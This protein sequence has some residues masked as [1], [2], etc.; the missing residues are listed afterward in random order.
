MTL[1]KD[2]VHSN[3]LK[4]HQAKM[5][6]ETMSF[7]DTFG[8]NSK[9]KRVTLDVNTIEDFAKRAEKLD[10]D[11]NDK[12]EEALALKMQSGSGDLDE[13]E[14]NATAREAIFSKGQSKRIWNEL[15]K[16]IDSSDVIIHGM[17]FSLMLSFVGHFAHNGLVL[18][19]RDPLGTRCRGIEKYI[20]EEAAHKHLLFALNK[21]D[22]IPS[23]MAVSFSI[24]CE[25]RYSLVP[26]LSQGPVPQ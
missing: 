25:P 12:Q 19:A 24:F 10:E 15:Y 26:S 17:L 3:G 2:N 9:R 16:V 6:L 14:E 18:D 1:I 13:E 22:L 5:K 23:K 20:R 11:F 21:C 8:P 4:Q 7:S